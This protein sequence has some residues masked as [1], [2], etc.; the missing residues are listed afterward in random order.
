VA[1]QVWGAP[2]FAAFSVSAGQELIYASGGAVAAA[3]LELAWFD[4][5][6]TRVDTLGTP[7]AISRL[8]FSPDRKSL[9][10]SLA[11]PSSHN[12][13]IQIF[14]VARGLPRRFSFDPA[15]ELYAVWSPD[16]ES[17]VFNSDRRGHFDLYRKASNGAADE[18]S[19]YADG[20]E[21]YPTSWSPDGKFLLYYTL[22]DPNGA[23]WVLPDPLGPPGS[24][25]PYR[26]VPGMFGQFSPNGKWVAYRSNESGFAIYAAPFPGPGGKRQ[27]SI[28][29]GNFPRWGSD[30]KE[31]FYIRAGGQLMAAEVAETGD[32]L[33]VGKVTPLFSAPLPVGNGYPYDVSADGRR[34]L[35]IVPPE[36]SNSESLKLVQ[37]WTAG[38]KK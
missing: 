27:I 14:D 22:N 24:A 34:F 21:K 17:I 12:S 30:G 11:D 25:K 23:L 35:M 33:E 28:G 15:Q 3:G 10:Y 6:G 4:R 26:F 31:I 2:Q 18:E 36:R 38:L 32:T 8:F 9:A 5:T 16:G 7:A 1:D 19:L 37:N 29:G 13:D 20:L